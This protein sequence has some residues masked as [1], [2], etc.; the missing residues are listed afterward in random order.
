MQMVTAVLASA[1]LAGRVA[2]A[3]CG[4]DEGGG[5]GGG[6]ASAPG[7]TDKHDQARRHLPVL[8][9]ASAYGTIGRAARRTSTGST[10]KDGVNGRK[11]EFVVARRRL[12]PGPG[13]RQRPAAR[14]AGE[15]LRAVQRR[16]APRR[17]GDLGLH[18]PAE[19]AAALRRDRRLEV[20]HGRTKHPWTIGWQPDYVTEGHG[21]R[22]LPQAERS[23][24]PRSRCSTRTTTSARTCS[25][26]SRRPSRAAR[27]RSSR[28]ESYEVTDPTVAPQVAKL[29]G[30][31]ADVSS[32]ITTPKSARRRSG[33]SPRH[34]L[35]AAAHPQQRRRLD[36]ARPQARRLRPRRASCR[37]RTTRTPRTRSGPTTR[38]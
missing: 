31:G 34:G 27:S 24:T 25:A 17:T 10:R 20:G 29:G 32:N 36:H 33:P 1:L 23:P 19:G 11:I 22:R 21:V 13:G 3:G 28:S 35:E 4:R 18:Q 15:G 14:H 7:V 2:A 5:V 30:S 26:A 8:G 12:R 38:R 37:R 6:A 16:W 9:P